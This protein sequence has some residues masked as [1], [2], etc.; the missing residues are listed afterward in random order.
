M[1]SPDRPAAEGGA[2]TSR[3][4]D[5]PGGGPA[6]HAPPSGPAYDGARIGALRIGDRERDEVTRLLHD[7]FAQGRITHEELDERL[8][9]TLSARTAEDLRRVT[10]DLPGAP[11]GV[12]DGGHRAGAPRPWGPGRPGFPPAGVPGFPGAP[13]G[14]RPGPYGPHRAGGP[15]WAHASW[16]HGMV[17]RRRGHRPHPAMFLI[18]VAAIVVLAAGP[19]WPPFLVL[20]FLIIALL[21]KAVLGLAHHRRHHPH[22][23]RH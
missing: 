2:P 18:P 20:K 11:D 19:M 9:A 8:D 14:A 16:G 21:V 4:G 1:V 12:S 7:A 3:G 10:A 13:A 5:A 22:P 15:P 23:T 6:G 17:P